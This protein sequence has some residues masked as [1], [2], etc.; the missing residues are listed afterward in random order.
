MKKTTK[1][2][3]LPLC[4]CCIIMAISVIGITNAGGLVELLESITD[5]EYIQV[6]LLAGFMTLL[7]TPVLFIQ[8]FIIEKRRCEENE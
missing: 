4:V 8:F 2:V 1:E 3:I 5:N 6:M 7:I